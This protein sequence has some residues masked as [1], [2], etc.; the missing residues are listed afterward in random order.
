MSTFLI[1]Y[2]F[3]V[4]MVLGFLILIFR[5]FVLPVFVKGGT[6]LGQGVFLEKLVNILNLNHSVVVYDVASDGR[7]LKNRDRDNV[8]IDD[9]LRIEDDMLAKKCIPYIFFDPKTLKVK[10]YFH[11]LSAESLKDKYT[12]KVYEGRLVL[13]DAHEGKQ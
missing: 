13:V 2:S 11:A 5:L 4:G 1:N 6:E 8:V 3:L 10:G 7:I 12:E 9:P